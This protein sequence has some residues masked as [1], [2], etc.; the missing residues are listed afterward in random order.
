MAL[1][2]LQDLLTVLHKVSLKLQR[3]GSVVAGVSLYIKTTLTRIRSFEERDGPFIQKLARF[4]T[5][6]VPSAGVTTRHT[7]GLTHDT[8]LLASDR[9]ALVDSLCAALQTSFEDT[10]TSIV[11][12]TSA[13][14]FKMWST[15]GNELDTFGDNWIRTLL[16]YFQSY[17][18]DVDQIKAEWPMLKSAVLEA[19]SSKIDNLPHGHKFTEDQE[20]PHVLSLY[21][22]ILTIPATSAACERS[23]THMKL[24]KSNQRNFLKES[25]LSDCLMIRLGKNLFQSSIL[26]QQ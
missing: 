18:D 24:V 15:N 23:F 2:F 19:F 25:S 26:K 8:G 7:Y 5:S 6:S 1:F 17:F 11:E 20:Y 14:N 10:K 22:I 4:E 13:A 9:K 21:D 12:A 16:H 3:D